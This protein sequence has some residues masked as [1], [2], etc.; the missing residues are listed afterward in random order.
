MLHY[1]PLS[2]P[3]IMIRKFLVPEAATS[4]T[5]FC[6]SYAIK[7]M[8]EKMTNPENMLVTLFRRE[9]QIASLRMEKSHQQGTGIS[10][11]YTRNLV[12]KSHVTR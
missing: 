12:E 2:Y 11:H 4:L 8:T 7:P 6:C 5:G 1:S 9:I 3:L 10:I